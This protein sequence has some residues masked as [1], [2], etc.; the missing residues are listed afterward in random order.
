MSKAAE[1]SKTVK[2]RIAGGAAQTALGAQGGQQ[3]K[4]PEF[5]DRVLAAAPL[6][7]GEAK[8][9]I[10]AACET[11]AAALLA[12]EEVNLPPL[13]KLRVVK[14]KPLEGG[15]HMLTVKLRVAASDKG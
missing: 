2:L 1:P 9:A 6:K 5:L 8:T 3:L 12:G 10:E 7:R 11:L 14:D 4:K 13:G 15:A